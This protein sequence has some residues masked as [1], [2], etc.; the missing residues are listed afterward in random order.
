[1]NYRFSSRME[2][3]KPS[4]IREILKYSSDPNV[5]AFSAGNPSSETFPSNE[6]RGIIDNILQE[7]PAAALQYGVT[8]GYEPLR[9]MLQNNL[10]ERFGEGANENNVLIMSGAQQIIDITARVFCEKGDVILCESPSFLAAL[11]AFKASDAQLVGVDIEED[12][13]SIEGLERALLENPKAKFLYTIPNFH[14]PTGITMSLEKRKQVYAL[15]KKYGICILEDDPYGELQF[16]GEKLPTIKSMDTE[17]IVIYSGSFSKV[18]APGLRV[19]YVMAYR[20]IVQKMIVVKQLNDVHS[21]LL[22]QMTVYHYL[23]KHDFG[24]HLQE[25]RSLYG[26][27]CNLMLAQ[28]AADFSEQ[29]SFTKPTGGLFI[30]C[31]L[32]DAFDMLQFCERAVKEKKVAVVPGNAFFVDDSCKSQSFRMNFSTPSEDQIITGIKILGE[33][34]KHTLRKE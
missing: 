13:I 30:W 12:G 16:S 14:N 1:M 11:S 24:Q 34:T 3:L 26:R 29:V 17:G 19:G 4:A 28:I 15:A 2:V 8:E 6:I 23:L 7:S 21:N 20:D 31:T 5:I 25:I 10:Q 32:P 33:M 27:K 18:I 22:A 9:E